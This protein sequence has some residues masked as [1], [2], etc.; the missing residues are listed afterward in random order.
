MVVRDISKE[1]TQHFLSGHTHSITCLALS[2]DGRS[3]F[4]FFFS[5]YHVP[6]VL[7]SKHSFRLS[8][9]CIYSCYYLLQVHRFGPSYFPWLQGADHRVGLCETNQALLVQVGV[10]SPS[11]KTSFDYLPTRIYLPSLAAF[12]MFA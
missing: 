2:P 9:S 5:F 10:S 6:L 4:N 1:R 7:L 12:I 3:L 8:F 11:L